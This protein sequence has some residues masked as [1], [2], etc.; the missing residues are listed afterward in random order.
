MAEVLK[1][2]EG[3]TPGGTPWVEFE[4]RG[5]PRTR[6]VVQVCG[7]S[8]KPGGKRIW[9][10]F[11]VSSKTSRTVAQGNKKDA[12]KAALQYIRQVL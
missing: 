11:F 12:I 6:V 9:C 4:I 8:K 2:V 5:K 7:K 3:K 10:V 1:R